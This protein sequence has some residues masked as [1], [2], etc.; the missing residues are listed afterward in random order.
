MWVVTT[1][2]SES[3]QRGTLTHVSNCGRNLERLRRVP[4]KLI[5][6]G[7]L[8]DARAAAVIARRMRL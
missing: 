2:K 4:L 1:L 5:S 6:Q 8:P 7:D 3:Y